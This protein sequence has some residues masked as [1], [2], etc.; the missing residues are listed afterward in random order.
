MEKNKN[1]SGDEFIRALSNEITSFSEN[2][3]QFDDL[4]V[5]S[6]NYLTEPT[7]AHF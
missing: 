3:P 1:V 7:K 4:T 5:I 2:S 6:I